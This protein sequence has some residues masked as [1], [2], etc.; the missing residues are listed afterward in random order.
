M[1]RR[2]IAIAIALCAAGVVLV[3]GT[4]AGDTKGSYRVRAIFANAF[5]VIPGEDVK[6]SGV[7]V[8]K[9]GALDVT[10]DNKAAVVLDITEPGFQDFRKDATCTI[11]PQ[12]LIGERYVEC[13]PTQPRADG[14]PAAPALDKIRSGPGKGEYLLPASQ[15]TKPI[16]LDLVGN[17]M[18]L[19][20]RERLSVIINELGTGL[21]AN[22]DELRQAIR[23]ADPALQQTDQVLAILAEQNKVLADLA[24]NGDKVLAPLARDRAKV[25][26]F[27]SKANTTAVATAERRGDL[28]RNI[29]KLPAFLRQLKPT[30]QRLGGLADQMT[31]VLTDLGSSAP[32]INRFIKE[33]GPFSQAGIPALQTLGDAADVGDQALIKSRPIVGDLRTFAGQAKP[34]TRNLNLLLTS[35]RDT[36]GIERL[37]DLLYF[38][39]AATNGYDSIGHYLRAALVVTTCSQYNAAAN[40][41]AGCSARWPAPASASAASA[42]TAATSTP[43]VASVDREIAAGRSPALARQEAVAKGLDPNLLQAADGAP[44]T[45]PK[46]SSATGT[47]S[48]IDLPASVLPGGSPRAKGTATAAAPVSSGTT[49]A[50]SASPATPSSGAASTLLDYLLGADAATRLGLHRGEPDPHRRGHHARGARGGLPGLQRQQRPAVRPDL[51]AGRRRPQRRE[52]RQGQRGA[53]RG[54]ARRGRRR[55]HAQAPGRRADHR[56]AAPQARDHRQAAAQGL[57]DPRAAQVGARAQVRPDHEGHVARRLPRGRHDPAAPGDAR[58]GRVRRVP[59]HLRRQDARGHPAAAAGLRR[60][61]RRPRP[62]P[63]RGHP[64]PQ[65]AADPAHPGGGQPRRP[66][67]Q[68]R[69]VLRVAGRHRGDRRPR[70]RDP[71]GPAAQPG[72]HVR[73]AVVGRAPLPAGLDQ[74]RAGGPGHRDGRAAQAAPV[75]GQQ[76]GALPRPAPGRPRAVGLGGRPGRGAHRRHAG[77]QA[78]R[79]AQP[80]AQA[81]VRRAAA[82]R[83]GPAR[84]ARRARPHLDRA[85]RQPAVHRHH[86]V[87]DGLQLLD[88]AVPQ[89][90]LAAEPGDANGTAQRFTIVATPQGPNNEGSPAS[91]PAA[92]PTRDNYL[93]S[94]PY[95]NTAMPGQTKECE[96][97]NEPFTAGRQVIGNVPGN[98]GTNTPKT[99]RSTDTTP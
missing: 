69:P 65:P 86:A 80:G 26:D 22:G 59:Q 60:R 8:G 67:D 70:R 58:A 89:R 72:H 83:R 46:S 18:R 24:T 41:G 31:P 96:A 63:P 44:A 43:T 12:S 54:H 98:Q 87:A 50:S 75:P 91:A 23:Q 9:I 13:T 5:T 38:Q 11:R 66:A 39:A 57:H 29:Q 93:H 68:A 47:P 88:P 2:L 28:E 61:P 40:P 7:R 10:P 3:L 73:R 14:D 97:G 33:L 16:D 21:A 53:H 20:Y 30:M 6:I 1:T 74:R 77:A 62:G 35:L 71:G 45:T 78:L 25:A 64:G 51:P 4:G 99:Q 19:P 32:S 34:L 84:H 36:G 37:M 52:P 56:A 27:V 17:I 55:H 79:R 42:R 49:P 48:R 90:R 76:R 81:D 82:L 92:G 85:D 94:N 95:P 15:N